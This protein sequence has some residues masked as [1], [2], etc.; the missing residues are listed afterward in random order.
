MDISEY[1]PV[2]SRL[3]EKEQDVLRKNAS[4]HR[5]SAGEAI[6]GGAGKCTGLFVVTEGQIRAYLISESGKEFTLFRLLNRDLCLFSASC[7]MN[8][9]QSDIMVK[10]ERDSSFWLIPAEVYRTLMEESVVIS[11]FTNEILANRMSEIIWLMEQHMWTS[12]DCRLAAF[13]LEES[14]LEASDRLSVTHEE[15]AGHLGTAREV[16]TR[17]LKHFRSEGYVALSRGFV[18]IKDRKGLQAAYL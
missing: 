9:F 12:F 8:S 1:L 17:M 2:W 15:I 16:V 14:A 13:L 3:T 11:N 5:V 7:M 6:G 18:E 10:A 4:L